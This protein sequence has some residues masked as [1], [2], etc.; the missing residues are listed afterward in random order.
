MKRLPVLVTAL[1]VLA[2][3]GGF[4]AYLA[5]GSGAPAFSVN[6]HS[7][8]Q[9]DVNGELKDLADNAAFA[10]LIKQSGSQAVSTQPGSITSNYTAGWLSLRIAQVFVDDTAAQRHLAVT[11][12]DRADADK[13]A[14]GLLGSPAVLRSLPP[15]FRA[16]LETRFS[17]I[18][19]V[20]DDDLAH[21]AAQLRG[22]ALANCPSHRFVAHILVP[23]QAEA[24]TIT[25]QLAAGADFATLARQHSIDTGSA[26]QG[27]ELGCLDNQQFVTGFQQ[28]AQTQPVGQV[29]A[30]VQTQFGFHLILVRDQ[31]QTADLQGLALNDVLSLAR[32][33]HV[34]VD[35]RYGTW[36]RRNGRVI[37][38]GGSTRGAAPAPSG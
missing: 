6:G 2:L 33:E 29:S 1:A 8:S 11:A 35:P 20:R 19:A 16:N 27:G 14:V 12:A 9:S 37:P 28:V 30:P 24:A 15:S 31:P 21:H 26:V 38:P 5:A 4:A 32:G 34:T 3:A 18:A 36:D 7:V 25:G 17:R 22:A 10:K 13:L 23:S